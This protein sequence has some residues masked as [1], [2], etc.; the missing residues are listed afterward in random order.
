MKACRPLAFKRWGGGGGGGG[1]ED[2]EPQEAELQTGTRMAPG[3]AVK[4]MGG[5]ERAAAE[6][7]GRRQHRS[8]RQGDGDEEESP[9]HPIMV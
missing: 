2:S 8:E 3:A 9:S 6:P 4:G 7:K 5:S 1:E